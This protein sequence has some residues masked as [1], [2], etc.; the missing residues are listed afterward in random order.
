M[1]DKMVCKL[2]LSKQLWELGVR[3][4]SCFTHF[5]TGVTH[6]RIFDEC[7][8]LAGKGKF[9]AYISDE[10]LGMLPKILPCN[11]GHI[12]NLFIIHTGISYLIAYNN[13]QSLDCEFQS[14]PD[15]L[16]K[17]LIK[18]IQEKII[19]VEEINNENK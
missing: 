6:R 18:L 9:A 7:V 15:A 5:V 17:M 11:H 4:E 19:T 14:L 2:E 3:K 1:I 16:A 10:L 8:T 13:R 12:H